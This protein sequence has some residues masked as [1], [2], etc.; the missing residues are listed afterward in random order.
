MKSVKSAVIPLFALCASVS[1]AQDEGAGEGAAAPEAAVA[2]ATAAAKKDATRVYTTIPF[3]LKCEG[4]AEVQ[5]LPGAEWKAIEEGKFYPLGASFRTSGAGSSLTL[6]FGKDASAKISGDA[7]FSTLA[8]GLDVKSRTLVLGEGVVEV[9]LPENL[10]E[11]LFAVSAPSFAVKNAAGSSRYEYSKTA[12][13]DR[14]VVRCVTGTLGLT[15]RH[16]EIPQMRAANEVVVTSEHDNLV[17]T[18][19]NTSGDYIVKLDQGVRTEKEVKD[20]GSTV[21]KQVASSSE[22]KLSPKMKVSIHRAVPSVG[23]R[24]SVFTMAFDAAGNPMGPGLS[25]CEGRAEVNSGVLVEKTETEAEAL[26]KKAAEAAE[27]TEEAAV[28][29]EEGAAPAGGDAA[30]SEESSSSDDSSSDDE[31]F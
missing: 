20:D 19:E 29:E 15:G 14:T 17:T 3:C 24:M 26:K 9:A 4:K 30:S 10:P 7:S 2:A 1:F 11:G 8:Q 28:E 23:E 16:Y 18:L 5:I 21:D 31:E 13:G 6:S 27:T 25:F 22:I 12:T